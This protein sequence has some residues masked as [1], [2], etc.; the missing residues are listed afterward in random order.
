MPAAIQ[1]GNKESYD[2]KTEINPNIAYTATTDNRKEKLMK[3]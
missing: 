1:A 2:R 3:T